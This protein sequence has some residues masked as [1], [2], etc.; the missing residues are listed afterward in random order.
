MQTGCCGEVRL[1][2]H[3]HTV[4]NNTTHAAYDSTIFSHYHPTCSALLVAHG[5]CRHSLFVIVSRFASLLLLVLRTP[6]GRR[7][8][9]RRTHSSD[10]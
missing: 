6:R 9:A 7:W 3:V 4:V 1:N 10:K 8:P 2:K 5:C